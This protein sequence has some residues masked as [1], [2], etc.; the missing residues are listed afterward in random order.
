MT[1]ELWPM[2]ISR[3]GSFRVTG[4]ESVSTVWRGSPWAQGPPITTGPVLVW[5]P[6]TSALPRVIRPPKSVRAVPSPRLSVPVPTEPDVGAPA[7]PELPYPRTRAVFAPVT[8]TPPVNWLAD[9]LRMNVSA[10]P[11]PASVRP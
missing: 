5:S 10:F 2:S 1:V 7:G 8:V 3:S 11:S 9:E 4:P 6:M